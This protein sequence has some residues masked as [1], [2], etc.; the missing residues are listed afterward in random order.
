MGLF[1][2]HSF[3]AQSAGFLANQLAR[4]MAN[5]LAQALQPISLAPAQF[6]T[7]VQLWSEEGL[8]QRDLVE[9][10][11]VE[12]ATMAGTLNRMERDGLITR[13]PHPQDSRAQA[14]FLTPRG[15][16][17]QTPAVQAAME[18]NRFA[19]ASLAPQEQEQLLALMLR[20]VQHVRSQ[21]HA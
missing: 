1:D 3:E 15:R 12:Q 18:V 19:L 6:A 17:L 14:I 20:V 8:T 2:E 7:L 16:E 11:Q 4:L 5:T 10:L 9:R 21:R 13:K